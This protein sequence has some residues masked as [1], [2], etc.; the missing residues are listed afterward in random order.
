M[1]YKE[2]AEKLDALAQELGL[3]VSCKFAPLSEPRN[4]DEKHPTINWTVSL[5]KVQSDDYHR[6]VWR[7]GYSQGTAYLRTPE[8]FKP[9]NLD[10]V[11][12]IRQACEYGKGFYAS[13]LAADVF[14]VEPT[15]VDVLVSLLMDASAIDEPSFEDWASSLGYDPDSRKAHA[16][17]QACIETALKLRA[18]VGDEKFQAMRELASEL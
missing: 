10:G 12:A 16:I 9:T 4:A 15:L 7:G 13:S 1:D 3:S 2:A 6:L 14:A 18:A 8:R 11:N 17:W 5:Y